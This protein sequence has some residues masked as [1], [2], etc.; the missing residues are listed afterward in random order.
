M[1]AYIRVQGEEASP[2][3]CVVYSVL[4]VDGHLVT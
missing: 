3:P 1:T 2:P 4:S